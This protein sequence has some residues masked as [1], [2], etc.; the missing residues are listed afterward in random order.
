MVRAVGR[1]LGL[2]FHLPASATRDRLIRK[3]FTG[4]N[5]NNTQNDDVLTIS[6]QMIGSIFRDQPAPA[7]ARPEASPE[8]P[9]ARLLAEIAA[10]ASDLSTWDDDTLAETWE[11]HPESDD[12]KAA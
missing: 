6:M 12:G 7:P 8:V 10:R 9:P 1:G 11:A 5:D 2:V 4:G 3:I